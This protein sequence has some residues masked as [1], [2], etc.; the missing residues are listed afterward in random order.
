MPLKVG[1]LTPDFTLPD[2]NGD[3]FRFSNLRGTNVLLLFYVH[4]FSPV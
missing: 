1:E 4:D 2:Q 3:E